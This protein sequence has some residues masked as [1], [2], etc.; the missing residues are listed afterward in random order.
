MIRN[1][2]LQ[3][4]KS[5]RDTTLELHALTVLCGQNGVGKSSLIQS[6]LLL[7]QTYSKSRLDDILD[8]N[9]PLCFIGKTKDALYQYADQEHGLELGI[10]VSDENNHYSWLFDTSKQ[11]SFL[12]R[13][14]DL[15]DSRGFTDLALFKQNF[16]YISAFRTAIYDSDDYAVLIE[17]QISVFQGKGELV[18]QYLFTY[19]KVLR[20]ENALLHPS[21][22]SVFLLDQ[23]SAWEREI[24][25]G[26][27]LEA[28]QSGDGYSIEYSFSNNDFGATDGFSSE[29]V[30]FGLSY[31]LPIIVAILSSQPGALLLIE[32]PEAH[33]HPYGQA[34][35]A[36]LI[37]LAGQCGIQI[38][39]ETHSDHIINGILVQSKKF[40]DKDSGIDKNNIKIYSFERDESKHFT[41]ATEVVIGENGR[42]MNRPSGFFDQLGKDLRNLL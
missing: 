34:K 18:A 7:R 39:V 16:Q 25:K 27:I 40:E 41:V 19:G 30:G 2:R 35:L 6:L 13:L 17:N 3:N 11:N 8:L 28:K 4:F 26:V 32:N 33:L 15:D 37:C 21:E 20:V 29:N 14:N 10:V 36:E 24:S 42:I 31:A 1:I 38:I 12:K 9:K 22:T 23:T 5:H